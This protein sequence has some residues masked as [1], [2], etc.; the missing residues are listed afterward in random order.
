[1]I[2]EVP[3]VYSGFDLYLTVYRKEFVHLFDKDWKSDKSDTPFDEFRK[4]I[5]LNEIESSLDIFPYQVKLIDYYRLARNGIV[6]PSEENKQS[7]TK[8]F[9]NE[10]K[11]LDI[12]RKY[13]NMSAAPND[14]DLLDFHDI[15]LFCRTLLDI[16]PFFDQKLDPGNEKLKSTVPVDKWD[17]VRED[18]RRN[19]EI[20]FLQNKYGISRERSEKIMAR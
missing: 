17:N 11:S 12:V 18:R 14:Y 9:K 15:K 13:Y 1:M 5:S 8:F 16:L 4:N 10:K 6:H 19:A 20:G 2:G 7:A 3:N